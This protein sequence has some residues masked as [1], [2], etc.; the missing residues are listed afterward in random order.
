MDEIYLVMGT[1]ADY[2]ASANW[3]VCYFLEEDEAKAY[4]ELANKEEAILNKEYKRR[5]TIQN[6]FLD[7]HSERTNYGSFTEEDSKKFESFLKPQDLHNKYD[8]KDTN[9]SGQNTEFYYVKVPY[10]TRD[11]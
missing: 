8:A 10:G 7:E 3:P 4:I 9:V 11:V 5:Q 1:W 2:D 6:N